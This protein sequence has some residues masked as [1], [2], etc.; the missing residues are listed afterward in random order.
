MNIKK[1]CIFQSNSFRL[2]FIF[3]DLRNII[4]AISYVSHYT[5]A[6]SKLTVNIKI[7]DLKK[8]DC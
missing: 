1:T 7:N 8:K 6:I 4:K 5:R 3:A 2:N